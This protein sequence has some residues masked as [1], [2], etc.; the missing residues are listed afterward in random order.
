M[1]VCRCGVGF[2]WCM[3][4]FT[5]PPKISLGEMRSTG[6]RRLLVHCGDYKCNHAIAGCVCSSYC[7]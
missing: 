3:P 2:D 7:L 4:A 5:R 6:L 1:I